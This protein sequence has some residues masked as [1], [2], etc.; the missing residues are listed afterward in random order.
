MSCR[1]NIEYDN[2]PSPEVLQ[3]VT[4]YS[5]VE[6]VVRITDD[7]PLLNWIL[8]FARRFL[9]KM[10][11]GRGWKE[12]MAQFGEEELAS[13][14]K[15]IIQ[16]VCVR[17][18]D[19]TRTIVHLH[20]SGIVRGRSWTRQILSDAWESMI[21]ETKFATEDQPRMLIKEPLEVECGKFYVWSLIIEAHG[22]M[23]SCP[24]YALLF[25]QGKATKNH[26]RIVFRERV[27]KIM[28]GSLAGEA[29]MKTYK[30]RIAGRERVRERRRARI[31]RGTGTCLRNPGIKMMSSWRF[32]MRTH[33]AVTS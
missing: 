25:W 11:S 31:E 12:S 2:E 28:D 32:D 33:L 21:E 29:G 10:R 18:D 13:S 5:C 23:E 1:Y 19:R 17:H 26:V 6:V 8:H 9:N 7:D 16:G 22:H 14:V 20:R 4:I 27:G 24:G 15:R 30:D 3:E